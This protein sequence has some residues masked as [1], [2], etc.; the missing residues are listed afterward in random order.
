MYVITNMTDKDITIDDVSLPP[1]KQ[2]SI[3]HI[4]KDMLYAKER[5]DLRILSGDETLEERRADIKAMGNLDFRWWM[6]KIPDVIL[7]GLSV[8]V[9][10]GGTVWGLAW[11]LSNQFSGIK[12]FV[13]Q[14]IKSVE[15]TI[16]EKLEYHERHDDIR[17]SGL[18]SRV[19]NI[20]DDLWNMRVRNAAIKGIYVNTDDSQLTPVSKKVKKLFKEEQD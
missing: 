3:E 12:N 5:G 17:F 6:D 18:D 13:F 8:G 1:K 7:V 14:Q 2:Y 10:V 15:Q 20:R 11:W 4:T 19:T 16:L 9:F